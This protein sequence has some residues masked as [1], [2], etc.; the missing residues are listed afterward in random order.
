MASIQLYASMDE[1]GGRR[2]ERITSSNT[3]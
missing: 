1:R 3:N 2:E